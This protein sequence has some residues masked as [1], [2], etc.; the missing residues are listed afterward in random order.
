MRLAYQ[1]KGRKVKDKG[2]TR[3]NIN[4]DTHR[5]PYLLNGKAYELQTSIRMEDD[6][7]HQPQAPRLKVKVARSRDQSEP[8]W[9]NAVPV[10][11]EAGGGIPCRSN[12][13]ATLLVIYALLCIHAHTAMQLTTLVGGGK[14]RINERGA[15]FNKTGGLV[16]WLNG[17][18]LI[19][20]Q[21]AFP[22][23]RSTYS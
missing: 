15:M 21:R 23:L 18:T 10:T 22:V 6:D 8:F 16:P 17:R 1:F 2:H 11:L 4:A 14:C 12:P 13:A 20:D 7:P 3:L 19:F 5:T 9:R